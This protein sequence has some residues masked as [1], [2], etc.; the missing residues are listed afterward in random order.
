MSSDGE[1]K[2]DQ[3]ETESFKDRIKTY[4]SITGVGE[5]ARRYFVM[6]AFDG[7]LT[8]L[9]I[10]LGSFF[11]GSLNPGLIIGAGL[12][13]SIA[14]AISGI[15]GAY[16]TEK[17]EREKDLKDLQRALCSDLKNTIHEKASYFAS[18]YV[19]IVDGTAPFLASII[20]LI[21]FFMAQTGLL[22]PLIALYISLGLIMV[23]LFL[24]GIFL[25][26][27]SK[28]NLVISGIKMVLAGVAVGLVS[29][30]LVFFGIIP[31]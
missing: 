21:P 20:A 26:K 25:G 15:S 1:R 7:A 24:L 30:L 10:I 28:V 3:K 14:M 8:T 19:A 4:F 11:I 12:G 22:P 29:I 27:I 17:A 13:G 18:V 31:S 9:G 2:N 6:N 16:M 5:I 23:M